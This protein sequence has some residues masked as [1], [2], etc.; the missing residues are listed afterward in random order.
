MLA[1][2]TVHREQEGGV[3]IYFEFP[4]TVTEKAF[5]K[6][7]Q[8]FSKWAVYDNSGKRPALYRKGSY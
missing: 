6:M 2:A 8:R 5:D 4:S 1:V 7:S 3:S